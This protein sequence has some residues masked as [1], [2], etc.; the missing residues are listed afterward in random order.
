MLKH[1]LQIRLTNRY[2]P[3]VVRRERVHHPEAKP[4]ETTYTEQTHMKKLDGRLP[5]EGK[6]IR[7]VPKTPQEVRDGYRGLHTFMEFFAGDR[8]L[9]AAACGVSISTIHKCVRQGWVSPYLALMSQKIPEMPYY[10]AGLC[11][12]IKYDWEWKQAK[13]EMANAMRVAELAGER[14]SHYHGQRQSVK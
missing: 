14:M 9:A 8:K 7:R 1:S 5:K 6:M 3:R 2:N 12:Y 4:S 13:K 11:S 10:P